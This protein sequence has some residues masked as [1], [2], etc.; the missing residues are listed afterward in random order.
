MSYFASNSYISLD[1]VSTGVMRKLATREFAYWQGTGGTIN[2]EYSGPLPTTR[3]NAFEI[4]SDR[5]G[6]YFEYSFFG[7]GF[8]MVSATDPSVST[9]CTVQLNGTDLT[10]ANFPTA[11]FAT[12]GNQTYNDATASLNRGQA[13]QQGG[14]F[15]VTGLPLGYYTVRVTNNVTGDTHPVNSI[16]VITPVHVV[17][18]IPYNV[19]QNNIRVGSNSIS[20]SIKY[21]KQYSKK[22]ISVT[23][24]VNNTAFSN[25]GFPGTPMGIVTQIELKEA[26]KL[27]I[28]IFGGL[29]PANC[30]LVAVVNGDTSTELTP[31]SRLTVEGTLVANL[32][33]DFEAGTHVFQL[34]LRTLSGSPTAFGGR[35]YVRVE[36]IE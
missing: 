21:K 4:R 22:K 18:N 14:G 16:D 9:D 17:Q 1:R 11:S 7:T 26:K 36:E 5:G 31:A 6:A 34:F 27:S 15:V 20:S 25:G 35:T 29:N 10:A 8:D 19:Y 12:V 2:W 24:L 3:P 13:N 33:R 30:Q 23:K 28:N 32:T